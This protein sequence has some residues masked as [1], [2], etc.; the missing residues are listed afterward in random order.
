[1]RSA[2]V[3]H[4]G[5]TSTNR[6]VIVV[7][8]CV[9]DG[10]FG[11][12]TEDAFP[13]KPINSSHVMYAV[14]QCATIVRKMSGVEGWGEFDIRGQPDVCDAA[15][16]VQAVEILGGRFHAE[17]AENPVVERPQ[18]PASRSRLDLRL[19]HGKVAP[20]HETAVSEE[21]PMDEG[22][23]LIDFDDETATVRG[24]IMANTP[25]IALHKLAAEQGRED[26]MNKHD[27][28]RNQGTDT[29]QVR[30]HAGG[31]G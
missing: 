12:S 20:L 29:R 28:T 24:S 14:V 16:R 27:W 3:N 8:A 19:E 7:Y 17:P 26:E 18:N 31:P 13:V 22:S 30:V 11:S 9:D 23:Y 6:R 21:S 15:H 1:M 4:N 2:M 5:S 25:G 10:D